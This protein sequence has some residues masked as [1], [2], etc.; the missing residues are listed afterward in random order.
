MV[1]VTWS[2]LTLP[3]D[4]RA[5]HV[6][7]GLSSPGARLFTHL[8]STSRAVQRWIRTF[9]GSVR[10]ECHESGPLGKS[11]FIAPTVS[12]IVRSTT[13]LRALVNIH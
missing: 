5:P 4:P 8:E 11:M 3:V 9:G 1:P 6:D 13:I 12:M 7:Y 10:T 2:A